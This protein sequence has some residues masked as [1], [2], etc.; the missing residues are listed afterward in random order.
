MSLLK[1]VA[2]TGAVDGGF[3][4]DLNDWVGSLGVLLVRTPLPIGLDKTNGSPLA[5]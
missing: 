3:L 5:P 2:I 1:G 4:N